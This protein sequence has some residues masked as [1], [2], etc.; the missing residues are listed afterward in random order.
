VT[1]DIIPAHYIL[2]PQE[3]RNIGKIVIAAGCVYELAALWSRLPTITA[4]VRRAHRHPVLKWVAFLWGG[5]V[6]HHFIVE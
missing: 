5:V 2:L 3:K 4:I 1:R 6:A